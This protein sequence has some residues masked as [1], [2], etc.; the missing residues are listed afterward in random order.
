MWRDIY[1]VRSLFDIYY[2]FHFYHMPFSIWV[3]LVAPLELYLEISWNISVPGADIWLLLIHTIY[4]TKMS[5][6]S[7]TPLE[8]LETVN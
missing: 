7:K 4:L 6:R 8:D 5:W 1:G 2:Y 3:F